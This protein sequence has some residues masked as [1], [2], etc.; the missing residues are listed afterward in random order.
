M[1]TYDVLQE[2]GM[3]FVKITLAN[4][5]VRAEAGALCYMR[6]DIKLDARIPSLGQYIKAALAGESV[7]RPTYTGTGEVYLE[8]SYGGFH[9]LT[10][11]DEPWILDS[12]AYWASDSTVQLSV[13]QVSPW[14]SFRA[15]DGFW[16]FQ[17]KV[18]GAGKVVLTAPGPVEEMTIN[19]ERLV[20]DGNYV[21]ART[22]GVSYR[23]SRVTRSFFRNFIAGEGLT[24]VYEGVGKVLVCSVPYW[25]YAMAKQAQK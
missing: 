13:H 11:Q 21:I 4:E 24:R 9:T 5:T 1:A 15:G 12:G 7:V 19:H 8:S 20:A 14:L 3:N 23:L 18:F 6:G 10:L 2:E 25:R 22:P 16:H 17:T